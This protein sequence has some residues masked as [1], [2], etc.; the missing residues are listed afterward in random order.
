MTFATDDKLVVLLIDDQ[1]IIAEAIRRMLASEPDVEFHYCD[2]PTQA[3]ISSENCQPT[4]ILQDLVMPQMEGLLLVKFLRS[5]DTITA[6]IP[7]KKTH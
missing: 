3:I 2:D 7:V 1:P 4:V 5:H 6:Q